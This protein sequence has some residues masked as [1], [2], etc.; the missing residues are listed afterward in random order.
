ML[1]FR[2]TQKRKIQQIN[3][4]KTSTCSF[5]LLLDVVATNPPPTGAHLSV[6]MNRVR[7]SFESV[8]EQELATNR[9]L[10]PVVTVRGVAFSTVVVSWLIKMMRVLRMTSGCLAS[11]VLYRLSDVQGITQPVTDEV[12]G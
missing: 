7:S 1:L 3:N 12:D 8:D 4:D 5:M 11:K 9:R 2:T 10:T 6:L